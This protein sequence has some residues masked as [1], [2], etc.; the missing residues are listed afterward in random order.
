[1]RRPLEQR[2]RDL[3]QPLDP[4]GPREQ[5]VVTEQGVVQQ[6]LIARELVADTEEVA[7][8]EGQRSVADVQSR[9]GLLRHEVQ[10]DHAGIGYLEGELVALGR[11]EYP[12][13][14][15]P[16]AECDGMAALGQR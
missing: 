14:R 16:E 9:A 13:G 3:P 1:M 6:T 7:V 15:L 12:I 11:C 2:R 8:A 4:V 5:G 10:P